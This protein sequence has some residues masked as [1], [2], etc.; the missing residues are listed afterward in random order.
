M[1]LIIFLGGFFIYSY[2]FSGSDDT[3]T[4]LLVENQNGNAGQEFVLI[5]G[6]LNAI[7]FDTAFFDSKLYQ[8]LDDLTVPI[9]EEPRGRDNPFA[10]LQRGR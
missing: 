7:K 1:I 8:A 9:E 2:F 6:Q 10:P 4:T 3:E 5:L